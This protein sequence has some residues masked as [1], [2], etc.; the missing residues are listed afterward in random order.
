VDTSLK[1]F[2]SQHPAAHQ[3]LSHTAA[4]SK[5]LR[6]AKAVDCPGW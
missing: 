2:E 1:L 3:Q 5:S 4:S 6:N